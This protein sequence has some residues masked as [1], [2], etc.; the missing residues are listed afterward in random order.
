MP[1]WFKRVDRYGKPLVEPQIKHL[2][3]KVR[4][5]LDGKRY[6]IPNEDWH[7]YKL[8]NPEQRNQ[9]DWDKWLVKPNK[10]CEY[11]SKAF[12]LVVCKQKGKTEKQLLDNIDKY[13]N[14]EM[15]L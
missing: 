8:W 10:Y 14:E 1:Y 15:E 6:E 11:Q 5:H 3:D 7:K 12:K 13:I 2:K 9:V 4:I